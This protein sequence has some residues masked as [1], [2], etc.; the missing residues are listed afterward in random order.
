MSFAPMTVGEFSS[1]IKFVH[2]ILLT[3]N[4]NIQAEQTVE[5]ALASQPAATLGI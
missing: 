3:S 4:H 1:S 2:H 5:H